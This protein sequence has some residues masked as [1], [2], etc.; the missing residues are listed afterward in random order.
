[1]L[2]NLMD[3]SLRKVEDSLTQQASHGEEIRVLSREL[4][5]ADA[6]IANLTK[7]KS[8]LDGKVE[9]VE[10]RARRIEI[11][12]A[13]LAASEDERQQSQDRWIEKQNLQLVEYEHAWTE[14]E[15]RFTDIEAV[16]NNLNE[17]MATYQTT[18]SKLKQMQSD[19]EE[20]IL[21]LERRINEIT[22]I[23]RLAE[24][25][26]EQAWTKYQADGQKR[27]STFKLNEDERWREHDRVHEK[28]AAQ[29]EEDGKRSRR[30]EERMQ[31]RRSS[32]NASLQSMNEILQ[33]WLDDINQD[34]DDENESRG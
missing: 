12:V 2:R 24:N 33:R 28:M 14:W 19:L 26:M 8:Q 31:A 27:W 9:A 18:Y 13:E 3:V 30:T 22:E 4:G 17:R 20:I 23:Q 11:R 32:D 29:M 1:V 15:R 5:R 25:R 21:R 10:D 7:L 16:S 34:L 6:E